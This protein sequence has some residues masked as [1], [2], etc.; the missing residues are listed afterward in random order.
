MPRLGCNGVAA[1][2]VTN[3]PAVQAFVR[4]DWLPR[5]RFPATRYQPQPSQRRSSPLNPEPLS[6]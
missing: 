3:D 1:V 5:V 6:S 4:D 2:W